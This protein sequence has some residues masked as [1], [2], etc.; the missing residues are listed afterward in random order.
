MIEKT[1]VGIIQMYRKFVSP[2]LGSQCRFYPPCSKYTE[3]AIIKKG[4][5]RGLA[6]GFGRILKCNPFHPGGIDD[7][8]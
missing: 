7:V 6:M 1:I 5:A 8:K 2:W 4:W 3:M